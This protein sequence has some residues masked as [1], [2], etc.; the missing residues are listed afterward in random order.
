MIVYMHLAYCAYKDI[1]PGWHN[2]LAGPSLYEDEPWVEDPGSNPSRA[3]LAGFHEI[4]FARQ[5]PDPDRGVQHPL[6][7]EEVL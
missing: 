6:G 1:M 5:S 2:Q 4:I 3:Y 7:K